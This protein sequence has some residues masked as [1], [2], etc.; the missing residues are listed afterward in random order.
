MT[1]QLAVVQSG[2]GCDMCRDHV[3]R[4]QRRARSRPP[5]LP[6]R[7]L[8]AAIRR[9]AIIE[10][11]A[12]D[13]TC[14]RFGIS[15]RLM[16]AWDTG[17]REPTIDQADHVLTHSPW[18]WWDVWTPETIRRPLVEVRHYGWTFRSNRASYRGLLNTT[19]I[20][21]AG[22]DHAALARAVEVFEGS[23]AVAV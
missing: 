18:N 23:L 8:A 11:S 21:D 5:G 2:A 17:Q 15:S 4:R 12:L 19:R 22:P 9:L 14:D 3:A 16:F 20:G 7:P 10:G 13:E 6:G 1:A